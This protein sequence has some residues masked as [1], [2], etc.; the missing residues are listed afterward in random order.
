[1][2]ERTRKSKIPGTKP[3]YANSIISVALVL[4]LI[5]FFGL[6]ILHAQQLIKVSKEKIEIIVEIENGVGEEEILKLKNDLNDSPFMKLGSAKFI[7]KSEGAKMMQKEFGEEFL[8]LD[9]PNPLY[10][11][12]TFNVN[13]DYMQPDS[14]VEIKTTIKGNLGVSDVFYQENLIEAIS[15]NVRKISWIVLGIGMFFLIVAVTLIHNTIRLALHSNRFLIKNMELVGAS[16]EFISRPYFLKSLKHGLISSLISI[17]LLTG[18]LFL[19]K[20]QIPEFHQLVYLPGIVMIFVALTILG[21][22]ITTS[23]TYYVVNK[24][25]RMRVDELY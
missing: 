25:L 23:S 16:W 13:A 20:N 19:A 1:M 21:L 15:K 11:I 2:T 6:L 5:G 8:K 17:A 7:P 4:F 18:L 10:D 24:Y 12:L 22:I 9:L 3:N 14:L